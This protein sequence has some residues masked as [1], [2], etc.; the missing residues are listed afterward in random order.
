L[1]IDLRTGQ[2]RSEGATVPTPYVFIDWAPS[3]GTVFITGGNKGT[4]D[5][6]VPI[7]DAAAQVSTLPSAASRHGGLPD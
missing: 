7:G 5:R 4:V 3:G 2:L 1:S 6:R